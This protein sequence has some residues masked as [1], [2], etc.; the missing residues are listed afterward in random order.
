MSKN[1]NTTD[2]SSPSSAKV[3]RAEDAPESSSETTGDLNGNAEAAV[4][5]LQ[6]K[7][8]DQ[9]TQYLYLAAELENFKKRAFK[10]R[11]EAVKFG[12]EPV[13]RE[14]LVV[15]NDLDKALKYSQTNPTKSLLDGLKMVSKNFGNVLEKGGVLPIDV[16]SRKF[17]PNLHEAVGMEHSAQVPEGE[18][19]SE[20]ERGYTLH[21][22]LLR[23]A[24]VIVSKGPEKSGQ[25]SQKSD[26]TG[27]DP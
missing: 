17:D 13:A 3:K 1:S 14:F 21:G 27:K 12:W 11:L 26:E 20:K 10:E 5:E 9:E 2:E 19:L 7:L 15:L 4:S 6:K 24:K 16:S 23:P 22:R 18:I 8:K 25:K